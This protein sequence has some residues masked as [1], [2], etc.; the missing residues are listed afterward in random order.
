[1][2]P[3][4]AQEAKDY[5]FLYQ[6]QKFDHI[7]AAFAIAVRHSPKCFIRFIYIQ[8]IVILESLVVTCCCAAVLPAVTRVHGE[9]GTITELQSQPKRMLCKFLHIMNHYLCFIA[10]TTTRRT[11]MHPTLP[12]L[13]EH[14]TRLGET[15]TKLIN[16][17]RESGGKRHFILEVHMPPVVFFRKISYRN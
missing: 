9:C 8:I 15:S 14:S 3:T 13:P 16:Y 7:Q 17:T 4:Q 5:P 12:I 2:Y 1:M 6:F 11:T 10:T